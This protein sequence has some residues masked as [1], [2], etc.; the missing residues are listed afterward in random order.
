MIDN[1]QDLDILKDREDIPQINLHVMIEQNSPKTIL[2]EGK[3]R[4]I[5]F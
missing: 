3:Q 2:I 5:P 4:N 1:F